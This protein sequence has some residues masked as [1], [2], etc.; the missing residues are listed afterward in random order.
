VVL[1]KTAI[2]MSKKKILAIISPPKFMK[3]LTVLK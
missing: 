2:I 3:Y 1:R